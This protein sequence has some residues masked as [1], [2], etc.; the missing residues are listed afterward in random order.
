MA[1]FNSY[2]SLPEGIDSDLRMSGC[3]AGSGA[4]VLIHYESP[5]MSETEPSKQA[6]KLLTC[7]YCTGRHRQNLNSSIRCQ[8][9]LFLDMFALGV[10]SNVAGWEIPELN[11]GFTG[12]IEVNRG[13]SSTSRL[14]EG[15][16]GRKT[17]AFSG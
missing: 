2:V 9:C 8:D 16:M 12:K 11:G 13:F 7:S 1:M 4:A 5:G 3:C 15:N 14:L 17:L 10:S 6:R